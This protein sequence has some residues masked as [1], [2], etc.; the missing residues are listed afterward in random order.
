MKRQAVLLDAIDAFSGGLP[1]PHALALTYGLM[2]IAASFD[3][4]AFRN[5][6]LAQHFLAVLAIG[7]VAWWWLGAVRAVGVMILALAYSPLRFFYTIDDGTLTGF[8][9]WANALRYCAPLIVL[10]AVAAATSGRRRLAVILLGAVWGIGAW[11]S[12]DS[13]TTTPTAVVLL[14]M[15]LVLTHT[16]PV[17]RAIEVLADLAIGFAGIVGAVLVFY[18]AH[19]S[20]GAFLDVYFA[21]PRAIAV[22]LGD[23]WWPQIGRASCRERV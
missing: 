14:L 7:F 13:L 18:G 11:Y 2:K 5:A 9:G 22:G 12:Q 16:I 8:F 20:A 4:V 23:A 1:I 15:L 3:L 19:R 21:F 10:P 6:W 17:R